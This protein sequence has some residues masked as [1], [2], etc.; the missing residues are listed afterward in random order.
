MKT[1]FRRHLAYSCF[2]VALLTSATFT[3]STFAQNNRTPT[4]SV[5]VPRAELTI[6]GE[7]ERPLTLTSA[8]LAKMVRHTVRGNDHGTAGTFEG[9]ALGE[10]L[11]RAGVKFGEGLR[12]RN[13]ELFLVVEA[14][15]GYR[16]VFA[17][18]ELDPAFT[19]RLI[20]LA[21][22]RDGKLLSGK[23]GSLRVVTPDEKRQAR[24]VR[25]VVRLVVR[26][27]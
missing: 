8:D 23:E 11:Q 17:L 3:L 2:T 14:A 18:P 4:P 22:K 27:A 25:Q 26:R 16:A 9:V 20:I 6:S 24:W 21:D 1:S 7:V 5:A 13:L 10:I 19:D 15:D 12:G